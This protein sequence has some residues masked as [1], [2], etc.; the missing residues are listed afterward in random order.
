MISTRMA[1]IG[2]AKVF[3]ALRSVTRPTRTERT[4]E[5][6]RLRVEQEAGTLAGKRVLVTGSTRGVGRAI[7]EGFAQCGAVVVVHGRREEVA[8]RVAAE[9]PGAVGLGQDLGVPGAGRRLVAR[10]L[11]RLGGLDIVVN[12]AAIH[13]ARR[14]PIWD[15]PEEEVRDV[16]DVNVIAPF[17]V[18]AA[19][20]A[21]MLKR[22]IAGRLINISSRAAD[23]GLR[24]VTGTGT[25]RVSKIALEGLSLCLASEAHDVVVSTLRPGAIATDLT[26]ALFPWDEH[27]LMLP[28]ESIVG[29]A[30][31]LAT[32]PADEVHGRVFE[33][34]DLLGRLTATGT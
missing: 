1:R 31:Y 15:T 26:R 13:D 11:D 28:P 34:A 12:N 24:S 14:K 6:V 29:P 16:L 3:G 18:A 22:R 25:Y 5:T 9:W 23:T 10:A 32:A 7:A 30:F 21:S 20:I 4:L 8:R 19:A 33:Q 27:A 17:D 2:A